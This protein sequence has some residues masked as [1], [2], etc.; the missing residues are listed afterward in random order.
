MSRSKSLDC[1]QDCSRFILKLLIIDHANSQLKKVSILR[2]LV[3]SN[4]L[5]LLFLILNLGP[6]TK[7]STTPTNVPSA[8]APISFASNSATGKI[9]QNDQLF[10]IL[11]LQISFLCCFFKQWPLAPNSRDSRV[12]RANLSRRVTF[13]LKTAFGECRRVW[14]VRPTRLGTRAHDKIGCFKH[15]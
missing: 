15:K 12:T 3:N 4:K 13:F 7:V 11:N 9:C 8:V 5:P 10:L 14:R 6:T 1:Y 2:I